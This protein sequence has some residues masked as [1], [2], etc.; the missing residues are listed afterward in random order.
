MIKIEVIYYILLHYNINS[1]IIMNWIHTICRYLRFQQ[2]QTNKSEQ[3]NQPKQPE[4]QQQIQHPEIQLRQN[5]IISNKYFD[6]DNVNTFHH[7]IMCIID[8]YKIGVSYIEVYIDIKNRN[9]N[10][11][12]IITEDIEMLNRKTTHIVSVV[13]PDEFTTIR[14]FHNCKYLTYIKLP[15]NMTTINK[16]T[17]SHCYCL[18]KIEIPANILF[19]DKFA[20]DFCS[21]LR[22]VIFHNPNIIIAENAFSSI[23]GEITFKIDGEIENYP[24]GKYINKWNNKNHKLIIKYECLFGYILK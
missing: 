24:E 3:P 20:F 7:E 11:D 14:S 23:D 8:E 4:Y 1:I 18:T 10:V 17:F 13:F 16:Y 19:I 6:W 9:Y 15:Y 2:Q 5:P 22:E 12:K 21:N